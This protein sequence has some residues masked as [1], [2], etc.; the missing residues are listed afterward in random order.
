MKQQIGQYDTILISVIFPI[1][2]TK[3]K[4]SHKMNPIATQAQLRISYKQPIIVLNQTPKI[5]KIFQLQKPRN[6][7]SNSIRMLNKT[8]S[9]A[10][11]STSSS[12]TKITAK[13]S[14]KK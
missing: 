6:K 3:V 8:S 13:N 11:L 2:L 1:Q 14:F 4:Q 5:K 7:L 9:E 10:Q 12:T